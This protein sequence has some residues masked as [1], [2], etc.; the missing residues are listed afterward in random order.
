MSKSPEASQQADCGLAAMAVAALAMATLAGR[1]SGHHI[2]RIQHYVK[3]L[4]QRLQRHPEF[5]AV[6]TDAYI[7]ILF[8]LAPLHD[9]GSIGVPDWI[10]LKPSKLTAAENVIMQTH[11][12]QARDVIEQVE[13]A[14]TY[15]AQ[16]LVTLK[17]IVLSHHEKWDGSGYPQGL[18]GDKIPLAA[19]LLAIADVYDTITSDHVYKLGVPHDRAVGQIFQGRGSIFDPE[20]VDA[21]IEVQGEFQAIG[22]RFADS[23]QDMQRKIEYMANAIAE[24]AEQ[25][26]S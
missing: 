13:K 4:A 23:A 18:R 3:T 10:L 25:L 22:L 7:E 21:F 16:S 26:V 8:H 2:L 5:A 24:S 6:L 12:T 19:R 14:F 1:G 15:R 20:M 11:T 9:L 17:E